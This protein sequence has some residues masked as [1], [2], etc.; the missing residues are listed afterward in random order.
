MANCS[1]P[2]TSMS[3]GLGGGDGD[4]REEERAIAWSVFD[5][6][7]GFPSSSPE[8]LMADIDAAIAAFEYA[9]ATSAAVR[10]PVSSSS[11]EGEADRDRPAEAAPIYDRQVADEAYKAACAS[12]AA[13]KVDDAIQ[14]LHVALSKCPPDKTSALA[15]LR[16]LLDIASSQHQKQ[17]R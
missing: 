3:S 9:R 17:R 7:K 13:G 5:S 2:T 15:K 14:S 4:E 1:N 16:S 6:V 11:S 10:L 8:A 12:L